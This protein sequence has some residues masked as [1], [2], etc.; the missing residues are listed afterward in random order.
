MPSNLTI[1]ITTNYYWPEDAGSA[2][3]LTGLA[4]HLAERGQR[5]RRRDDVPALPR[6]AVVGA[7][8]PRRNRDAPRR[9]DPTA[10][11]LRPARGSRRSNAPAM[12]SRCSRSG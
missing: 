9:A 7:G 11:E 4:E 1:L 5:R 2:P 3:Y 6:V 8:A 12:S 10:L